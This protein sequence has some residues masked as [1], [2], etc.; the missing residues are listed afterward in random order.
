MNYIDEFKTDLQYVKNY[1]NNTVKAYESDLLSFQKF[2]NNKDISRV[3]SEDIQKYMR[4][5]GDKTDK[6][7][8]FD[9][10]KL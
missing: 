3:S 9:S 10:F 2:L 7:R 1:S 4:S 6:T 5:F 8:E